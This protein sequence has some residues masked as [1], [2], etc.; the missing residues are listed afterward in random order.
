[1]RSREF[2]IFDL[3]EGGF[4]ALLYS[5]R[6][7]CPTANETI[8]QCVQG[9]WRDETINGVQVRIFNLLDALGE[10][11]KERVIQG[12]DI[13]GLQCREYNVFP[14]PQWTLSLAY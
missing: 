5:S 1:M 11:Y 13:P 6:C 9:G 10:I 2:G 3:E 12:E 14:F 8:A 4:K 7:F